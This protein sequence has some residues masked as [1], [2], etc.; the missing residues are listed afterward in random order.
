MGVDVLQ[1]LV[2]SGHLDPEVIDAMPTYTLTHENAIYE[3]AARTYRM[4]TPEEFDDGKSCDR[5]AELFEAATKL[6]N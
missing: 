2:Q 5:F 1:D 6:K 3:P 4:E